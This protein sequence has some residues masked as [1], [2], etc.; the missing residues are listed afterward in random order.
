MKKSSDAA[1]MEVVNVIGDISKKMDDFV[2]AVALLKDLEEKPE[3]IRDEVCQAE[4]EK[5]ARIKDFDKNMKEH[6]LMTIQQVL[7]KQNKVAID[8]EEVAELRALQMREAASERAAKKARFDEDVEKRVAIEL[9]LKRLHYDKKIAEAEAKA[10]S[11][12]TERAILKK[13]IEGLRDEIE[14]QKQLTSQ[15]A[16]S[17]ATRN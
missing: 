12:E 6:R 11:F 14:S 2:N 9:D 13:T 17:N 1:N 5:H 15:L 4:M 7:Q 8:T 16:M 10:T 3:R